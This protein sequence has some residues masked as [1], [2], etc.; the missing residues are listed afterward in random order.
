MGKW[1]IASADKIEMEQR[2]I[3]WRLGEIAIIMLTGAYIP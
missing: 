3:K 2:P 1:Q